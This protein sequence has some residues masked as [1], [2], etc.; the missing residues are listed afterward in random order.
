LPNVWLWV[1]SLGIPIGDCYNYEV[2]WRLT[3]INLQANFLT[4]ILTRG[5]HKL[6]ARERPDLDSCRQD[7]QY[8]RECF[9]GEYSSFPSGHTSGAFVA[10]GLLCAHHQGLGLY[11]HE[12]LDAAACG[13]GLAVAGTTGTLRIRADRH[14][15]TDV[16][17]GAVI[18][19]GTGLG[20]SWWLHYAW[21]PPA[22]AASGAADARWAVV[23]WA[24]RETVGA[25][26][27][28]QF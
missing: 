13:L 23:P 9:L 14:Y 11:G 15:A 16:L 19:L 24:D 27:L 28:G 6:L 25:A 10:A 3:V 21:P 8:S 20:A 18:G 17:T 4:G 1:E 2:A 22:A 12:T 26:A 5:T 7:N